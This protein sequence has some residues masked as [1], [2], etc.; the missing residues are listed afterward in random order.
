MATNI[1]APVWRDV[2]ANLADFDHTGLIGSGG[3]VLKLVI[4]CRN[5]LGISAL[6]WLD[7]VRDL[8]HNMG[9]GVCDYIDGLLAKHGFET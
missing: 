8:S 4:R 9:Y 2:K 6:A 7:V 1:G 5:S 3:D